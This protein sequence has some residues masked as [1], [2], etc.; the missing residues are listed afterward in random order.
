VKVARHADRIDAVG[1]TAV[2]VVHDDPSQVRDVLLEGV[3]W[4]YP[5]AVDLDR[6]AYRDWGLRRASW[7]TIW[8][9]P[10]VWR[11]YA[12]LLAGGHRIRGAGKDLRQ[13]GGDFVVAA[14]GRIA[15]ARPQQRD[16]RPPAGQLVRTIEETADEQ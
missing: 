15:Y 11:Q 9:D 6:V 3:D 14:D 2:A 1:A 4:P 5:V 8:L 13:L 16:D 7:T 12:G 10:R